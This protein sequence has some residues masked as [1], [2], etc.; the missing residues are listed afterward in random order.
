[1]SD[2]Y[3][4]IVAGAGVSGTFAAISAAKSGAKTLLLDR[5]AA[6]E[7]GKKTNCSS[8]RSTMCAANTTVAR[9]WWFPAAARSRPLCH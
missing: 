4:V 7:P 5:N 8:S 3:D 9:C 1:M 2:D 6:T